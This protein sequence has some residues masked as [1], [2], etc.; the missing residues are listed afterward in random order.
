VLPADEKFLDKLALSPALK[1]SDLVA[2]PPAAAAAAVAS[3]GE[4]RLPGTVIRKKP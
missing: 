2:T 1:R 3:N 4:E